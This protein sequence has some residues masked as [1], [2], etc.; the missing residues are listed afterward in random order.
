MNKHYPMITKQVKSYA[1]IKVHK[2]RTQE[3]QSFPN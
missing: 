1:Q 2:L 3:F